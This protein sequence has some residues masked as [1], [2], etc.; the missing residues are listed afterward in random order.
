MQEEE[1]ENREVDHLHCKNSPPVGGEANYA[2]GADV[3]KQKLRRPTSY[4]LMQF[5]CRLCGRWSAPGAIPTWLNV[6]D[7]RDT[8]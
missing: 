3:M 6:V 2:N 4:P 7:R 1:I 5:A 8:R